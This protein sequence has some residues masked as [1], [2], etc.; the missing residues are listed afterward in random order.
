MLAYCYATEIAFHEYTGQ[1]VSEYITESSQATLNGKMPDPRKSV[2]FVLSA[3]VSYYENQSEEAPV[4]DSDILYNSSPS[5][6]SNAIA[7]L[8]K[9][10]ATWYALPEGEPQDKPAKGKKSKNA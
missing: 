9:M 8:I 6:I 5:E 2:Y 3:I 10:Y 1:T 7:E 4:K